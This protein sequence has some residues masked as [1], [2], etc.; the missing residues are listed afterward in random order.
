MSDFRTL[1]LIKPGS[2]TIT[3]KAARDDVVP[4]GFLSADEVAAEG[5]EPVALG[6]ET[7]AGGPE[8]GG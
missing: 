8:P 6:A 4:Y 3:L 5:V 1:T 7:L 2:P